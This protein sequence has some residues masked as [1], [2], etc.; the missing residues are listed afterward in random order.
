MSRPVTCIASSSRS[1]LLPLVPRI[2]PRLLAPRRSASTS[3]SAS[4]IYHRPGF[5]P[6]N[7]LFPERKA[8]LYAYYRH[9]LSSSPLVLLFSHDNLSVSDLF[10]LRRAIRGVRSDTGEEATFTIARTGV[11]SALCKEVADPLRGHL[12]GPTALV[13][14]PSLEP[15]YLGKVL[16]AIERSIRSSRREEDRNRVVKQPTMKLQVGWMDGERL[17]GQQE[18][19]RIVKMPSLDVL[20]GQVVGML[21]DGAR[22]VVGVLGAGSG[23]L[24]RTLRGLEEGLKGDVPQESSPP[25]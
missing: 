5:D 4:P 15:A 22:Q 12:V 2:S 3:S 21:E 1:Q 11:L 19:E 25:A 6:V 8:Y 13:T 17:V 23:G 9:L 16:H 20:R 24:L 14:A 7:R 18:V 10:K